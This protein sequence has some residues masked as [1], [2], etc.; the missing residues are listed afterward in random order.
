MPPGG[1]ARRPLVIAVL[2]IA[3]MTLLRIVYA[4]VIELR[5]DE[6]YYWTWSKEGA[7]SF[8][9]HPPMIAW[10]VRFGTAIFGDTPLGVR[11]GGIVAMLVTQVLL[12][13]I[14]RRLSHD[15]R[16]IVFAVLMPEAALYYGLLMAKVAP[17][18]AMIPFAVAMMWSLVRLA[19]SGDG[20]WW[21]AAGLFAGLSMLS[22]FTAIMFAP[23]VA[24]FLLVPDWRWRWL[25]SPYPYL[26][27]LVAIAAFSPVLIWNAQHDWASFRFQGVRATANYGISLRTIGDYIG[28]QFGLV[29]FVMLPVVLTGLVITA[30]R[31]YR[32]REPVAILLSTAVLVP[33]LYFLFKSLT[34]RVGD[35]WP[36]FMWPVGFAAAAVNLVML[37]R[38]KWPAWLIRS[39]L[40]WL[41]TA[42]ISGIAFVII[43]FLYY[44]AAP[45]NLLGKID[46]IGA[47]A[48][49]EQVAARAQ[50]ALDETGATWIATTD[51]R[52]YAMM[53][54][55]F[56]GRVPVIEINERGRFQDF[57]DPGMDRVKGH[58]GI[59]VGREP[60]NRSSLWDSIPAKRE[61][62]GQV[63]RRWR[64]VLTDIYVIEKLDGWTPE[65]SPPKGSPLFQWRVLA[66]FSLSPQARRG[67]EPTPRRLSSAADP[68][69]GP[70]V[71]AAAARRTAAVL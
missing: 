29:G 53:R 13:D 51:Y 49:Y 64:G 61:Q 33:F 7:P 41:K 19:Q 26:A 38:E 1:A 42:V 60:D 65:L 40:F 20:R 30:W 47:E 63:E 35:T 45:W 3:A 24:A 46:P 48:G 31:G 18:V 14:V 68:S 8:L 55:L 10:F 34:L 27:V 6:A 16:A 12:A 56:R 58:A 37:S 69:R 23:A 25:R 62:L 28:L 57:R 2:V 15:V 32:T 4:S 22:K 21:L 59:Y 71:L 44:V 50:A 43:V 66:L 54:W 52:T 36:M 9:D 17:D 5:T 11:F 67:E 39:S 70:T